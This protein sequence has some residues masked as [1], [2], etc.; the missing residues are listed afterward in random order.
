MR[1]STT[2][3]TLSV[4]L[5]SAYC[6]NLQRIYSAED[7]SSIVSIIHINISALAKTSKGCSVAY[8]GSMAGTSAVI[9]LCKSQEVNKSYLKQKGK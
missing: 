7:K 4:L 3:K 1:K 5:D 9:S 2:L 8:L 6:I